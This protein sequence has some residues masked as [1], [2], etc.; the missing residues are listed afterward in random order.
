MGRVTHRT[1]PGWTYFVTTKCWGNIAIFQVKENADILIAKLLEYRDQRNYL[2]HDFVLMP[3]HL[4]LILTPGDS[5]SLE[6]AMQLI[7]GGSSHEIHRARGGRSPIWQSGFHESKVQDHGDYN[8]KAN[9]IQF[10]PVVA[11]LVAQ[12]LD[13]PYGSA[14]GNFQMDP[15][16]QGLKPYWAQQQDVGA[17]APTPAK[18]ATFTEARAK[19]NSPETPEVKPRPSKEHHP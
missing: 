13:W 15:F 4:H 19:I 12:P 14:G 9:Y 5:T 8:A 16:P 10:N 18:A 6:K 3:N 1:S 7:K 11:K 2:L 17:E